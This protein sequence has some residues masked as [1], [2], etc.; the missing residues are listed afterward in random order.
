MPDSFYVKYGKR[1]GD[2]VIS[3]ASLVILVPVLIL[4]SVLIRLTDNGPVFYKHRRIGLNFSPFMLYKFRTMTVGADRKGPAITKSG[5]PRITPVGRFLRR[6]KLDELP[7]LIN[8]LRGEISLVGPRP[9][10]ETYVNLFRKD[11]EQ[12]LSVRPGITDFA[13][14]EYRDEEK[15]LAGFED[16]HEGYTS[17]VL[18]AK[19]G[20]YKKYI[21]QISF[22]TDMR[23]VLQTF[24]R[25]FR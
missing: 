5:D 7:Q 12:I 3:L 21:A 16:T 20:L 18:P 6:S 25:L 14:I 1:V 8:V 19:I 17:V 9:E 22:L 2:I 10:V 24:W 23:I 11:Y 13:A 15:I 4:I